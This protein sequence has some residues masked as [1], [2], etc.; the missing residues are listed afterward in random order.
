MSDQV[1][2]YISEEDYQNPYVQGV[3]VSKKFATLEEAKKFQAIMRKGDTG[4]Y[5]YGIS[6]LT[7]C[8]VIDFK[9]GE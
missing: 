4:S 5:Y 2:R 1:F 9:E 8:M 3:A 7:Q 6:H